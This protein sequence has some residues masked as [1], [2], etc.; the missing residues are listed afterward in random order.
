MTPTPDL[1]QALAGTLVDLAGP[2]AA[3]ER[4]Q[5]LATSAAGACRGGA[6]VLFTREDGGVEAVAGSD[7]G[8][9][10][11][12]DLERDGEVGPVLACVRS[13]ETAT[14]RLEAT[15]RT[16]WT[17]WTTA[18]RGQGWAQA[19]VIPLAAEGAVVGGLVLLGG[20]GWRPSSTQLLWAR[21]LGGVS[22]AGLLQLR[23]L[24]SQLRV[25]EQLQ[26]ALHTR[27]LI[28]QAKGILAERGG[29]DVT[30]AFGR[31]RRYA[32]TRRR[33][34]ADVAVEVVRGDVS[35]EILTHVGCE[36]G[37]RRGPDDGS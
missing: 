16:A 14:V 6:G 28:E 19:E 23:R 37:R 7:P 4:A 24:T 5:V 22:A 12:A 1:L 13:G 25:N 32:R 10:R 27:I 3:D 30:T 36:S 17:A 34:L 2:L 31:L 21:T 18:A 20:A 8:C 15:I 33:R 35:D 9:R 29:L 11:L 26:E